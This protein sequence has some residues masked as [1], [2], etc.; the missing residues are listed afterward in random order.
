MFCAHKTRLYVLHKGLA[1]IPLSVRFSFHSFP[2]QPTPPSL[3]LSAV[4][5]LL[6]LWLHY[7][8]FI[9]SHY[10]FLDGVSYIPGW[11][12]TQY[13]VEDDIEL[14]LFLLSAGIRGMYTHR[15][16][17]VLRTESSE[18]H[19]HKLASTLLTK[20]HPYPCYKR[21]RESIINGYFIPNLVFL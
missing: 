9:F 13:V 19:V 18:F 5:H 7:K 10:Y 21:F 14:L 3:F 12:Q 6:I 1:C 20:P 15:L 11:P 17:S 8:S 4:A 2:R 16:Y